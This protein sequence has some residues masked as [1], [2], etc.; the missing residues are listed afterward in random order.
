MNYEIADLGKTTIIS[1][2]KCVHVCVRLHSEKCVRHA[3]N[4]SIA[5]WS[6]HQLQLNS[7]PLWANAESRLRKCQAA[8]PMFAY[9]GL[10]WLPL[11]DAAVWQPVSQHREGNQDKTK[12]RK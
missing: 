9:C 11:S 3:A 4:K 2:W 5:G 12:S 1:E 6:A 10:A 8:S 7:W